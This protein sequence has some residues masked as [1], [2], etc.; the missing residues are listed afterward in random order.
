MAVALEPGRVDGLGSLPGR[1]EHFAPRVV[2]DD[3][4]SDGHAL[5]VADVDKDGNDEVFAGHR[6][7]GARV[8]VYRFDGK[9]WARTIL[10]P[11][12]TAQDLRGG[13]IDGDGTPDIVAIGGRSHNIVW[14]RPVREKAL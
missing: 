7:K 11:N 8:S 2:L 5:W 13:D 4:L 1:L 14:F 9:T 10:D 6:G 12:L 3:T